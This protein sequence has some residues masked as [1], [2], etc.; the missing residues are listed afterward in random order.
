[1]PHDTV[2]RIPHSVRDQ[3]NS[4]QA[5]IEGKTQSDALTAIIDWLTT[6][7]PEAQEA[8]KSIAMLKL[9]RRMA[10]LTAPAV[11]AADEAGSPSLV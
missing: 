2:I 5:I 1:M 4:V 11:P 9:S 7:T 10:K 3:F 8:L 6:G